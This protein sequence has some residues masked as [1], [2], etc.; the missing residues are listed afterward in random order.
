MTRITCHRTRDIKN[1]CRQ[2]YDQGHFFLCVIKYVAPLIIT[3]SLICSSFIHLTTKQSTLCLF[4]ICDCL[5]D[6]CSRFSETKILFEKVY[7]TRCY[8]KSTYPISLKSILLEIKRN[9]L[10]NLLS[11]FLFEG[12]VLIWNLVTPVAGIFIKL[13]TLIS[14]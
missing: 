1:Y 14:D 10:E 13:L 3:E 11:Y 6:S 2:T 9:W 7:Q 4:S 12:T 8:S 5:I